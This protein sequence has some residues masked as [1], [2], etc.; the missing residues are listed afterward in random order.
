MAIPDQDR[1]TRL[2]RKNFPVEERDHGFV[3]LMI[4][5]HQDTKGWCQN[6]DQELKAYVSAHLYYGINPR[7]HSMGDHVLFQIMNRGPQYVT[8][9]AVFFLRSIWHKD[10]HLDVLEKSVR[11]FGF[12][13]AV[14]SG[15]HKNK[16]AREM[17]SGWE[18]R[19]LSLKDKYFS[20]DQRRLQSGDGPSHPQQNGNVGV[21]GDPNHRPKHI[22]SGPSQT[23]RFKREVLGM[24][25]YNDEGEN[26]KPAK[27]RAMMSGAVLSYDHPFNDAATVPLPDLSNLSLRQR[28]NQANNNT[29]IVAMGKRLDEVCNENTRLRSEVE[30]LKSEV[31]ERKQAEEDIRKG[32]QAIRQDFAEVADEVLNLD[33]LKAEQKETRRDLN[34]TRTFIAK[35]A[36]RLG[37]TGA[38]G[39]VEGVDN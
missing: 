14:A 17:P 23:E 6:D 11:D 30:T 22:S 19:F 21:P 29:E 4:E 34:E 32:L 37:D 28:N 35:L 7:Q 10:E 26:P 36:Q 1:R 15:L 5:S 39:P 8:R 3:Q 31:K 24:T 33:A 25:G 13:A 38:L 2:K 18:E 16:K 20:F 27:R 12:A 9:A